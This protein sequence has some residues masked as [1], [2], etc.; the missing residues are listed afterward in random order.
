[1]AHTVCQE[2]VVRASAPPPNGSCN[3]DQGWTDGWDNDTICFAQGSSS[4][5]IYTP[6]VPTLPSRCGV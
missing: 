5:T 3:D 6:Q 2:L 1:M 4:G